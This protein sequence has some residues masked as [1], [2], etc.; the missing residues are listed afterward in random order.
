MQSVML[1]LGTFPLQLD[2]KSLPAPLHGHSWGDPSSALAAS[3]CRTG[4]TSLMF[5]F[6]GSEKP[7][8]LLEGLP[9][10][11]SPQEKRGG[12]FPPGFPKFPDPSGWLRVHR[13]PQAWQG[14]SPCL[15]HSW[16]RAVPPEPSQAQRCWISSSLPVCGASSR[17]FSAVVPLWRPGGL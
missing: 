9:Q 17:G 10:C 8:G 7:E 2:Y 4:D 16:H 11:R 3:G 13:V 14:L 15:C 1:A 12:A 5:G 6:S